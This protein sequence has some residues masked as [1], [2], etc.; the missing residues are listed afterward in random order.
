MQ[1]APSPS[2]SESKS[3]RLTQINTL[4][5][6]ASKKQWREDRQSPKKDD[7]Q[8]PKKKTGGLP[9]TCHSSKAS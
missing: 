2:K 5:E 3:K 7:K 4:E 9:A 1:Q 6:D 8:S